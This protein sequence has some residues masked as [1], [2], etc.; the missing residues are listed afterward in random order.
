[1]WGYPVL[2]KSAWCDAELKPHNQPPPLLSQLQATYHS[3]RGL[4]CHVADTPPFR[5]CT[6]SEIDVIHRSVAI[7]LSAREGFFLRTAAGAYVLFCRGLPV[8]MYLEKLKYSKL[9]F[10]R[11][12]A[13]LG[14]SG[15]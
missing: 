1:M 7:A 6:G 5:R 2:P 9:N 15:G 14:S 10:Q 11:L 12:L 4:L 8:C 3:M 13:W